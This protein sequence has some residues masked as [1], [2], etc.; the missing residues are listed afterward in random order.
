MTLYWK[1]SYKI[2]I[3][4]LRIDLFEKNN[5]QQIDCKEKKNI[6]VD[7]FLIVTQAVYKISCDL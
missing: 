4:L 7:M 5:N 6:M 1:L 2:R 3:G